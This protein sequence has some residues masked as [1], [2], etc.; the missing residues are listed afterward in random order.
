MGLL[1]N[2]LSKEFLLYSNWST[3]AGFSATQFQEHLKKENLVRIPEHYWH[4]ICNRDKRENLWVMQE[5]KTPEQS[6][7]C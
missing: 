6:R 7:D 4:E 2:S 3:K 5:E 1:S